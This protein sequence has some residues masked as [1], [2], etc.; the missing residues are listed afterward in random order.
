[1][2]VPA[3]IIRLVEEFRANEARYTHPLYKEYS[4]RS[5]FIN[6]LFEELGW[7]VTATHGVAP[8][9]RDVVFEDTIRAEDAGGDAIEKIVGKVPD[10]S[11]RI[12]GKRKFYVEAKKPYE[13]LET[14][15]AHAFQVRSY[16]WSARLPICILTDFQQ[17]SVYD[18]RIKPDRNDLAKVALLPGF[19]ITYDQYAERWDEIAALLHR[20]AVAA[21][22]LDKLMEKRL[23]GAL[24]VDA[25]FLK[26]ISEWR[27][28]L[29][30]EIAARNPALS[31]RDLNYAVQMT[32]NRI[33]F[34][35]IAEDRGIEPEEQ[36]K[37][38]L[39]YGGGMYRRLVD[40]F[41]RAHE[42][43][44]SGLFHFKPEKGIA[45]Q[46]D[47]FT[48]SLEIGDEPIT[49][50][51]E[52]LYYPSPYK[53]DVIPIEILGQVYEQFLGKV[54]RI[55]GK[56]RKAGDKSEVAGEHATENRRVLTPEVAGGHLTLN[57]MIVTSEAVGEQLTLNHGVVIEDKPEVRKAGGVY[58]TPTY[59]VDYIVAQT[60]G[61]LLEG[62]TPKEAAS[63]R[64]L[65]PACGSGSFLIGA[66][67][68][69]LDWHL[70]WY[71]ENK[72][73]SHARGKNAALV[74]ITI[75]GEGAPAW[76]L[77]IGERKR[78]LRN[79][80]YGVDIDAQAVEVT[81]LSLLLKVL[82]GETRET[83]GVQ[84]GLAGVATAERVLPDLGENIKSGNSLIGPDFYNTT[85]ASFL[86]VEEQHRINAFDWQSEFKEIMK[87]GGFDTVIGNPP[88]VRSINLKE[89]NP[90]LWDL[91][92]SHY[93]SA[94]SKEWDIY[95][96][97]VEKGISLLRSNGKLGYILPNKFLNS[98]VGENLR[99]IIAE[100]RYLEKLI[101]FGAFQI[102]KGAT[103]YT[104]LLFLEK[105]ARDH[106]G[107]ARYTGPV[108][109]SSIS[110]PLPEEAPALWKTSE[111]PA[112][113]LSGEVWDFSSSAGSLMDKLK[114]WPGL[115]TVA[116][117]F[118]G[119]GTRADKVY[120]VEYRGRDGDL[121]RIYSPER[122]RE[123]LLEPIYL[124]VGL[125]GR[126]I[127]RYK[128]EGDP[129]SLIVPYEKVNDKYTLVA[130]E[131]LAHHAPRTLHYLLE[132]K[133][134]L[135]E[136]ENGRFAAEDWYQYGRPQ[137]MDRFEVPEKIVLPDIGNRGTCYLDTDSLW[138]LD[139]AYVI[140]RKLGD[141]PDLRFILGL[142][143][144]SL[145]THF[146]KETG[147]ALR[148]GYFRMKTAYLNPFPIRTINFS[149]PADK[150]RHDQMVSLVERMLRL[151]KD[152]AEAKSPYD[153]GML[154][155]QIKSTD[156]A[157]D[158][159]VYDLYG[160]TEEEIRVIEG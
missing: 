131:A 142:L 22:S 93:R 30:R 62:K 15:R 3:A 79:N 28:M 119:T 88:Y 18:C 40:L 76:R 36:L 67:S 100:G 37:L 141:G 102:F 50:I 25:A 94:S 73:E 44:N 21:G 52:H 39:K 140:V 82:E 126:N 91:Y 154:E 74:R 27:E 156:E 84:L 132:C 159:L 58:Y 85:Q 29:A 121:V 139:T 107:I 42:R 4:V 109:G 26:E 115:Q 149:D 98:Q 87:A 152:L 32:I 10:Y 144:S 78:I 106:A 127:S 153:K 8:E 135:D 55:T 75:G 112:S 68:Y 89:S 51:V 150:A 138:P 90:T 86:D 46:P 5:E 23:A 83:L 16:G 77:S 35:R 34:L 105:S 114:Q 120:M 133:P 7:P 155:R 57:Q 145:L 31:Q 66:Y 17:F 122:E 61:K 146:L 49:R 56:E 108:N 116:Q 160:L 54:I 118:Q 128:L 158:R 43:Y 95:L 71:T 157:I 20:D 13:E 41:T 59:I 70:R 101:H 9:A 123:Y 151:H 12:D 110:C 45:E 65:D 97:F 1:M 136:R 47:E 81:K 33:I 6:P 69:L 2:T 148:G 137:N 80:I 38:T 53:F 117:V 64:I 130:E 143:N 72:P 111:M 24:T 99:G 96:I 124:R 129:L 125:R 92:R 104:C 103:T 48:L 60:V 134:R 113:N 147:T 11:F 19:Y 14:N 63:L